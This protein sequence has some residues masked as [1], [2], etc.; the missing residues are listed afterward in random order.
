MEH[1][2][3][4]GRGPGAEGRHALAAHG[5]EGWGRTA[6]VADAQAQGLGHLAGGDG[7]AGRGD[8]GGAELEPFELALLAAALGAGGVGVLLDLGL[9]QG[10]VVGALIDEDARVAQVGGDV[11]GL[12][13]GR[14]EV[15]A[16]EAVDLLEEIVHGGLSVEA[17]GGVAAAVGAGDEVAHGSGLVVI[18]IGCDGLRREGDLEALAACGGG[19]RWVRHGWSD[20]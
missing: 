7:G 19:G 4:E 18:G 14:E 12:Q 2:E 13:G 8:Q 20:G 6:Y 1:L 9:A 16:G 17:D 11:A 10:A 15:E 5:G 3:V